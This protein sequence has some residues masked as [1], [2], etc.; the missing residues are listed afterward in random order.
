MAA[1]S[2]K[3]FYFV[4]KISFKVK[5]LISEYLTEN[6]ILFVLKP[7]IEYF[8]TWFGLCGIREV[9]RYIYISNKPDFGK[10]PVLGNIWGRNILRCKTAGTFLDI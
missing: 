4:Y 3:W 9:F 1:I 7:I 10:Y 2:T 8:S 6:E 5:D